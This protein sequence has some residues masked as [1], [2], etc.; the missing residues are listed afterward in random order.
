[1]NIFFL[2]VLIAISLSMDA[3][4]LALI[5]G[6]YGL[7]FSRCVILSIIVGIF[8]FF[9]PLCGLFFGSFLTLNF[10]MD[11]NYIVGIILLILGIS[12]LFSVYRDEEVKILISLWGYLLFG[13]TVSVDSFTVGIG[14]SAITHHYVGAA[15]IFMIFSFGFTFLGL[16][17]GNYLN[18]NFGKYACFIGGLLLLFLSFSYLFLA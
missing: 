12:M 4:S 10:V 9:M 3:F 7:S 2:C 5:Y 1:M 13:F 17:L 16:I 11:S 6:T 18:V 15:F 8:H 14:L